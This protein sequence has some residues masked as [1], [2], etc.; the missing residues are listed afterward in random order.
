MLRSASVETSPVYPEW[1]LYTL[2]PWAQMG[3]SLV[4]NIIMLHMYSILFSFPPRSTWVCP[5]LSP[6]S[7]ARGSSECTGWELCFLLVRVPGTLWQPEADGATRVSPQAVPCRGVESCAPA[8][9]CL[10]RK[11]MNLVA[12]PAP[13]F[14]SHF[15]SVVFW[16][17]G[18]FCSWGSEC[19]PGT[20]ADVE[21]P[22][23]Q[24][25]GRCHVV[26]PGSHPLGCLRVTFM[27]W[28]I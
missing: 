9:H 15:L 14:L 16:K 28:L 18:I 24:G 6:S 8:A 3:D 20:L 2:S 5:W 19:P 7:L 1:G 17:K 27:G 26:A 12:P 25:V 22:K 4:M 21:V 10:C 11:M 13:H 23:G